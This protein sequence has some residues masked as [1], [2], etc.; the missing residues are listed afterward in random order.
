MAT[1]SKEAVQPP[2][3]RERPVSVLAAMVW[4]VI[5]A[6]GSF[7]FAVR[8]FQ[9]QAF[10]V[11]ETL[12][13]TVQIFI[14]HIALV[15][16][17]LAVLCA[18]RLYQGRSTG[19]YIFMG[20]NYL[21]MVLSAFYLLH[22]WDVFIGFDNISNAVYE[23][24]TWLFGFALAYAIF[25]LGGRFEEVSSERQYLEL[26]GIL[27]GVITLGG[28]MLAGGLL[29]GLEYIANKY[30][31]TDV[32]IVTLMIVV[33]GGLA[34]TILKMGDYFGESPDDRIAWQGWLMVSPN[35]IGF[36]LFFAGPLLLSL[37]LSFTDS[38]VGQVPELNELKNYGDIL[39]LQFKVQDNLDEYAQSALSGDYNV[40]ETFSLGSR[41][42]VIGA[43]DTRFWISLRNTIVF[44]LLLIPMS[45]IPA[46]GL[47][48]ILD[49]KL[50]GVKF[51]RAVYFLPSVAAVVGTALIWRTALFSSQIG[52]INYVLGRFTDF[53]NSILGTSWEQPETGWLT[54]PNIMLLS[55]VIMVAWQI[56]GFNTVLFLAGLQ[57]IPKVL[58]EAASVDGA[59]RWHQFRRVTLPL[60]APTTFFVVVTTVINGLQV[61]NEPFVLFQS[62]PPPEEVSTVVMHLYRK[63]FFGFEFGYASS[64][65]WLLFGLIFIVTL[66]QFRISRRYEAY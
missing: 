9:G 31:Q 1:V 17:A 33:F 52:Y 41:R 20:L 5:L 6:V 43:K 65:A 12:G 19:R 54:D 27:I 48:V 50:P 34:Y 59:N 46:L 7:V 47:A 18:V 64:V 3:L 13:S 61:F 30:S 40:L 22:L 28:L 66:V 32:W 45:I 57:G 53:F 38:R 2:S 15:P 58:Y 55:L 39:S 11:A 42:L 21:G 4:S 8:I 10:D 60:L 35:I 62:D 56:I 16:T 36:M 23:N 63:G 29:D 44:C 25:W 37:Y 51:F 14:G 24:S 26:T 49:S